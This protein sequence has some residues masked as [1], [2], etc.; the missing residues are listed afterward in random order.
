MSNY[1]LVALDMDGTLLNDR[2]EISDENAA[3]IARALEAG[4][5]VCFSTGRGF[6]SALPF[7][8]QIG[9]ETPMITVNG[10]EIWHRPHVLHR[11]RYLA[12][13]IAERLHALAGRHDSVWYWGYTI[14][15]IYNKESWLD[16]GERIADKH[17][18]KFGYD[19]P[20][21]ALRAELVSEIESWGGLEI[22]NSSPTNLE[23]NPQGVSKAAALGELCELLGLTME[24]V[25]A[26][27]DSLNDI[28]AIRAAGLGVAMGNA[29][30][31]V[32][33]AA[34]VVTV[35]NNEHAVA[36]VIAR[37]VLGGGD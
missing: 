11:R 7:A 17:W 8:E 22:T 27:G 5:L 32:K 20:D 26:V 36:R 29:Q 12:P 6:Q 9:L 2:S 1:K 3:A 15:N 28:A 35:T 23:I 25:V 31:T 14:E 10:G 19:T 30:E 37:Y 24:Q 34:D 33:A 13:D 4:V 18:M 16:P 21:D